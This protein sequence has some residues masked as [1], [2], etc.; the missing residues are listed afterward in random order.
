MQICLSSLQLLQALL[1]LASYSDWIFRKKGI[2]LSSVHSF[3]LI[4]LAHSLQDIASSKG[5]QASWSD[6]SQLICYI[7][8]VNFTQVLYLFSFLVCS[9]LFFCKAFSF[10][11]LSGKVHE[12]S[13]SR[14]Y[15]IWKVKTLQS[16]IC[17]L[18]VSLSYASILVFPC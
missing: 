1:F 16:C 11:F 18:L 6:W 9:F 4:M 13:I 3:I 5:N 14:V 2:T 15:M 10:L 7:K 8:Q 17:Y 12:S